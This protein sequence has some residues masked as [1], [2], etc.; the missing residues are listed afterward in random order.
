MF[1]AL[2]QIFIIT[3][4]QDKPFGNIRIYHLTNCLCWNN[5][6]DSKIP[7]YMVASTLREISKTEEMLLALKVVKEIANFWSAT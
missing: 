4:R 1:K 7:I 3:T 5:R 2:F 6:S